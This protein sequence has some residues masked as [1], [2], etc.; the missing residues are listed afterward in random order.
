V[1]LFGRARSDLTARN[2]ARSPD[3]A[4]K[5]LTALARHDE[6]IVRRAVAAN[7]ST[8]ATTLE[9]L[10]TDGDPQVR[11]AVAGNPAS[12]PGA[13]RALVRG[14]GSG[15][16]AGVARRKALLAVAEHPNVTPELLRLLADDADALV[17]RHAGARA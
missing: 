17:A 10:A 14:E 1:R 9:R 2:A 11:V 15:G 16:F 13:L 6:A 3:T 4:P 7:P 12:P 5:Q 8:P